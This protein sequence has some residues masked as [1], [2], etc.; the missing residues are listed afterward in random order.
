MKG[1]LKTNSNNSMA[2]QIVW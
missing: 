2:T 1:R